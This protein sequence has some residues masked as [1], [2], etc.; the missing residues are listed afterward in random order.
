MNATLHVF[1][2]NEERFYC[3]VNAFIYIWMILLRIG[4]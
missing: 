4:W 3:L 2:M 1:N